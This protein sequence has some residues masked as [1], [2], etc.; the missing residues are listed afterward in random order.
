MAYMKAGRQDDVNDTRRRESVERMRKCLD[1]MVP[2]GGQ[3]LP[4]LDAAGAF[5]ECARVTERN[6]APSSPKVKAGYRKG[7]KK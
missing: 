1:L 7:V 5:L 4:R 3:D 2:L 6:A